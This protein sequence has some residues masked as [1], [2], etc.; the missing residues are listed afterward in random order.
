MVSRSGC[1]SFKPHAQSPGGTRE[2]VAKTLGIPEENVTVNVTLLGGGFGRKS[3]CDFA[4]ECGIALEGDQLPSEGAMDA[5]GRRP[6]RLPAHGFGGADR[7]G[8][9]QE[10]QGDSL[11]APQRRSDHCLDICRQRGAC[12]TLRTRHGPDRHAVRDRQYPVRE[13]ERPPRMP[14]SAGSARCRIFRAPSRSSRWWANSPMPPTAIKRT[15]S[16]N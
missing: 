7:S 14:A 4:L 9:R 10:R 5:R 13:S 16:S 6:S 2:D 8:P 3:K 15:C 11:A 1:W 12:G